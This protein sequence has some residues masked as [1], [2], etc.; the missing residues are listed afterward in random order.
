MIT[1]M[2]TETRSGRNRSP[3]KG[4]RPIWRRTGGLGTRAECVA[5]PHLVGL[6]PPLGLFNTPVRWVEYPHPVNS[7]PVVCG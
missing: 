3:G 6:V 7:V 5:Y 1:R 2:T 4:F